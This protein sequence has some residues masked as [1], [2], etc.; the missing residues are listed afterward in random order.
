MGR[1]RQATRHR[2]KERQILSIVL[3]VIADW[4]VRGKDQ[5]DLSCPK[6]QS[7]DSSQQRRHRTLL[8]AHCSSRNKRC[9]RNHMQVSGP[10]AMRRIHRDAAA[11]VKRELAVSP[12]HTKRHKMFVMTDVPH[13]V[14]NHTRIGLRRDCFRRLSLENRAAPGVPVIDSRCHSACWTPTP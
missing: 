14:E 4:Y 2:P 3:T 1:D 11:K 7:H 9:Q 10:S 13:A 5:S 12:D 8:L 6:T